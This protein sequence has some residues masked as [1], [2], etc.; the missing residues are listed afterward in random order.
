MSEFISKCVNDL[1]VAAYVSMHSYDLLGRKDR[2]FCFKVDKE[3]EQE[4]E[5]LKFAYLFSEYHYFDHCL[6]GLK[7]V[8]DYMPVWMEKSRVV[9]DLGVAAYLLMHKFKIVAKQGRSIYFEVTSE[10]ENSQFESLTVEYA[11][12]DYHQF[13]SK[14]MGLKKIGID[15]LKH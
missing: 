1:G 4:F 13:D 8:E 2:S 6:M 12:S 3:K 11:S 5:Q 10:E 14:L 15:F 7:K 9:T